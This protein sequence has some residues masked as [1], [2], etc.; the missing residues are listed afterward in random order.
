MVFQFFKQALEPRPGVDSAHLVVVRLGVLLL[1]HSRAHIG[2]MHAIEKAT[3]KHWSLGLL[4][5]EECSTGLADG[6]RPTKD[7]LH[8]REG[9]WLR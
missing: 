4:T 6:L 8:A 2:K 1:H 9:P 3:S 5:R 7:P